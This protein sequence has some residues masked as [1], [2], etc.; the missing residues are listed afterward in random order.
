MT[1]GTTWIKA[2]GVRMLKTGAQAAVA[3]I[4]TTATMIG[5]VSWTAV[6]STALLSMAL[7]FLTSLGGLPEV[8]DKNDKAVS[9]ADLVNGMVA[10]APTIDADVKAEKAVKQAAGDSFSKEGVASGEKETE[11]QE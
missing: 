4:G 1:Q 9:E 2:A 11:A 3:A 7:S 6:V 5:Q 8:S 10:D